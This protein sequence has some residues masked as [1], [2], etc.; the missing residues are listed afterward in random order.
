MLTTTTL[1]SPE[2]LDSWYDAVADVGG[3]MLIDKELLWTSFDVVAKL[4][5]LWKFKK[6]GHAGTLDPL[7]G[8]LLIVCCGKATKRIHE[9][10]ELSKEYEAVLRLGATTVT[11]D[12]EGDEENVCDVQNVSEDLVRSSILSFV[13]D[14]TQMPP[15]YSARKV[16]GQ[17]LYALARQGKTVERPPTH[18]HIYAIDIVRIELPLVYVRVRCSKGTYIRTLA[19]DIGVRIGCGA[20]LKALRRTA[21]GPHSVLDALRIDALRSIAPEVRRRR[22]TPI[23]PASTDGIGEQLPKD[24][25]G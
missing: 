3:V 5:S 12:A 20:Y 25:M 14:I 24:T 11:Y 19:H 22:S 10:Q 13:G 18:V 6:I 21:I 23:L 15:M 8:G 17:R 2:L 1:N 4:R 9:F 16:D 7:A